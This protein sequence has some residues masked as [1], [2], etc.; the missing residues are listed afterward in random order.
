M[1][2]CTFSLKLL[3]RCNIFL[4]CNVLWKLCLLCDIFL[5]LHPRVTVLLKLFL[6]CNIFLEC[7]VLLKLLPPCNVSLKLLLRCNIVLKCNVLLKLLL[8]WPK[9]GDDA[10]SWRAFCRQGKHADIEIE[11][12]GIALFLLQHR[13]HDD[14]TLTHGD[15]WAANLVLPVQTTKSSSSCFMS[16]CFWPCLSYQIHQSHRQNQLFPPGVKIEVIVFWGTLS[17]YSV[18]FKSTFNKATE[19]ERKTGK[20]EKQKEQINKKKGKRE[21][22]GKTKNT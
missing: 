2:P 13:H 16:P 17:C 6:H 9:F 14:V 21:K 8:R 4:K 1:L 7:N 19:T 11:P 3:L 22:Q 12:H 5:K 18:L 10:T 15:K 20:Q